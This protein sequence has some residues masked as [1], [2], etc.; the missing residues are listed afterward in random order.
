MEI[1][2]TMSPKINTI[3][4]IS[5]TPSA[6]PPENSLCNS[7]FPLIP[8]NDDTIPI[9]IN[10]FVTAAIRSLNIKEN[11]IAPNPIKIE[12]AIPAPFKNFNISSSQLRQ[13]II[14]LHKINYT[15]KLQSK[16]KIIP[17][18]LLK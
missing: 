16:K 15:I 11:N 5:I 13:P 2:K 3:I 9:Y 6:T 1:N 8:K 14:N 10:K 12:N 7:S 17:F 18:L 4:T